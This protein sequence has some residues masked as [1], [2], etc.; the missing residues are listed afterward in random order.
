MSFIEKHKNQILK[1]C[2]DHEVRSLY[3][4]GSV[5]SRRFKNESDIDLLVDFKTEDP[6]EYSDHYFEFKFELEKI[7]NREID[8]LESK[9]LKNPYLKESI[10]QTKELIYEQ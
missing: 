1:L 9:A 3:S 7:L 2:K 10:D 4:F 6:L 8:L 5:N